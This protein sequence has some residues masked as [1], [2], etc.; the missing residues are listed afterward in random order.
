M[1]WVNG[2]VLL[3]AVML[4]RAADAATLVYFDEDGGLN[5]RPRGLYNYDTSSAAST[6]R[7]V[8]GGTQRF[9]GMDR[10]A[11]D[12]RVVAVDIDANNPGGVA[13]NL[14][15]IDIDSGAT[16]LVGS[17]AVPQIVGVA[18]HPATGVLYGL[19]NGGGLYTLSMVSGAASFI[20]L[21]GAAERGLA[22]APDGTLYA[23]AING[24][25]YRLNPTTGAATFLGAGNAVSIIAEDSTFADDGQCYAV[26]FSGNIF[27]TDTASGV[28]ALLGNSGMGTGMLA[29]IA[30]PEPSLLVGSTIVALALV[31]MPRRRKQSGNNNH[32]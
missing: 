31:G 28:G 32:S 23:F 1:K 13:S 2:A 17:T 4:C 14:W 30:V 20:G 8:V 25:L 24:S 22:F 21:T 18:F 9:F 12:S 11:S 19:R 26:D 27:R 5:G 10:R 29:I 15:T 16:A 7:V 6:L 3:W